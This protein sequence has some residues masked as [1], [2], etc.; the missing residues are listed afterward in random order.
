MDSF[1]ENNFNWKSMLYL[2]PSPC[3]IYCFVG[4]NVGLYHSHQLSRQQVFLRHFFVK[5]TQ[6][7]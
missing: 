4:Y 5:V 1:E 3:F 6:Q 2:N 7:K